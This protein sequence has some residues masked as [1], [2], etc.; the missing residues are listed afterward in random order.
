MAAEKVIRT[1]LNQTEERNKVSK[2]TR[3]KDDMQKD[4]SSQI[5]RLACVLFMMTN[6]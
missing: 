2:E 6:C 5:F 4:N 3:N 1:E